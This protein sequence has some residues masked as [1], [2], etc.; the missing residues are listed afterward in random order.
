MPKHC[1]EFRNEPQSVTM[2][3]N[4]RHILEDMM[5]YRPPSDIFFGGGASPPV[6]RGIYAI[7]PA[8]SV[9]YSSNN[10]VWS[11]YGSACSSCR[12]PTCV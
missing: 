12:A 7:G 1:A 5:H 6:P 8:W 3:R 4:L 10:C 9:F 2:Q 11:V